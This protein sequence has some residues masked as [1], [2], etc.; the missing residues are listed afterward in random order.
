MPHMQFITSIV[1]NVSYKIKKK[2]LGI[3]VKSES[4]EKNFFTNMKYENGKW[5]VYNV[6]DFSLP[7]LEEE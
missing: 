5:I 2:I 1:V 7:G 3:D 6:Q 4:M